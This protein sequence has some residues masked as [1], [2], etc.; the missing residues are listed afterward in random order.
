MSADL[1]L[2]VVLCWHMH[3]PQY[4]DLLSGHY[5]LPWTYLHAIKDYVDMAA[6]LEA[7]PMARAVVNFVPIVL[8]QIEDYRDQFDGFLHHSAPLRD[9][10]LA[11]LAMPVLPGDASQRMGLIHAC[12]RINEKRGIQRFPHYHKLAEMAG[13]LCAHPHG[14]LYASDAFLGDLLVWYHLAWLGETVRRRDLRIKRLLD[15]GCGYSMHDRRQLLEVIGELLAGIIPRYRALA[16]RGQVEL[17]MTPYAHP[18]MPLLI[19]LN[20]AREAMPHAPMPAQGLYPGGETRVRWQIERG[21]EVFERCFGIR[22]QGCWPAEGAVSDATMHMLAEYGFAWSASGEGVLR[23]SL[24]RAGRFNEAA[25]NEWLFRPYRV[26]GAPETACFFRDDGLSDLIGFSYSEWHADD[27]VGNLVH[28]LENIAGACRGRPAVVSI[29]LDGEN[30]W[31]YYPENGYYF[32]SALYRRLAHHPAIELS[33]FGAS[34][35]EVRAAELPHL[36]PGSWV[37][38]TLSTW[39]GSHDKNRGWDMLTQ[40]KHAFDRADAA[41]DLNDAAKRA[42]AETQLAMCEGSDWFWWFGDYN[43]A[44]TVSDFEQLYRRHLANLYQVV[45]EEP[46]ESLTH[47]ISQGGGSPQRGGVMRPGQAPGG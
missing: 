12:L 8:E 14:V 3:Q 10:L 20:S 19:D 35:N 30:A 26:A 21:L 44:E 11:A 23:H 9:P 37:Y 18:I 42:L 15:K 6:H 40:A 25:R 27:A 2:R 31:E 47:S 28:H 13:W 46:P 45:G 24:A 22:P 33:T 39:I 16:Q 4:R 34:V 43:P 32:L 38:G 41:G 29:I 5:Q 1:P 36:V 17:S 7:E